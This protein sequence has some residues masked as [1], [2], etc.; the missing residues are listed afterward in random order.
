VRIGFKPAGGIRTAKQ[1][2]AYLVLMKEELGAPWLNNSLFR[3]GPPA[4]APF[5][6]SSRVSRWERAREKHD[7][8]QRAEK[9]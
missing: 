9:G 7:S 3:L 8:L 6:L 1:A 5:S 2:L 4:P